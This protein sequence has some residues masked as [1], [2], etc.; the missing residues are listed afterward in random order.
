MTAALTG[1][2]AETR[3]RRLI[4]ACTAS[5]ALTA[6]VVS[7]L[8]GAFGGIRD[9]DL[10][11]L[12]TVTA[13]PVGIALV[14]AGRNA[15]W[16]TL[17]TA[18]A[19][20]Q[21]LRFLVEGD[22]WTGLVSDLHAFAAAVAVILI[23][24]LI[25]AVAQGLDRSAAEAYA[26]E[27]R[28]TAAHARRM[29]RE[30]T[31]AM[32]HDDVLSTLNLAAQDID[33]GPA[34]RDQAEYALQQVEVL[35]RQ[36]RGRPTSPREFLALVQEIVQREDAEATLDIESTGSQAL[37]PD[38]TE[39]VSGALRQAMV[40]SVSH[41]GS[42]TARRVR[43]RLR[44]DE[45]V[46]RLT[47]DGPGFDPH[48]VPPS[49]L[50]IRQSILGRLRALPGGSAQ[51]RS[52][53][54]AGTQVTLAV[55]RSAAEQSEPAQPVVNAYEPP[56][57]GLAM[58]AALFLLAQ[59]G[60][61]AVVTARGGEL[62]VAALAMAGL[63]CCAAAIGWD[64]NGRLS[65][66]RAVTAGLAAV[67]TSAITL[68]PASRDVDH[69]GDTW[70]VTALGFVLVAL[71]LRERLGL[72]VTSGLLVSAVALTGAYLQNDDAVDV[73]IS[74]VRSLCVL[75][76]GSAFAF[77]LRRAHQHTGEIQQKELALLRETA[78]NEATRSELS[79][80]VHML[81]TTV[82]CMLRRITEL[83]PL[84]S[85]ERA[86]ARALE[87]LL[88]D[89]QRG[90]RLAQQPLID[91]AMEARRRGVD[92][93]LL[94]DSGEAVLDEGILREIVRWMSDALSD[95]PEG[96]F[97][98]RLFPAGRVESASITS[99]NGTTLF[100]GRDSLRGHPRAISVEV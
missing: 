24:S 76:V 51:V 100:R 28:R 78:W 86:E 93:C 75:A 17:L 40:N 92:V 56:M 79:E 4:A 11:W 37:D 9:G 71:A 35:S 70:Y 98:G 83:T 63:L 82:G 14:V 34:L 38:V 49:A 15:A 64:D 10:P 6:G 20:V 90:R 1:P 45:L 16:L 7:W 21:V 87:G 32:V 31:E 69:L 89:Q 66:P 13:V 33:L 94:D 2:R 26:A 84:S 5:I 50:G 27:Q 58:L 29:A 85:Q 54:G 88:R 55:R 25:L 77:A 46:I 99:R 73:V 91:T 72:A 68:L 3:A 43:V 80:R 47:D 96:Q 67:A 62:S 97:T 48:Q 12:L 8:M 95:T 39:A 53:P 18:T 52:A 30:R 60:L 81:S 61:A 44:P 65:L 36:A 23:G 57:R 41:A 19:L 74:V 22:F 59:A 42:Q